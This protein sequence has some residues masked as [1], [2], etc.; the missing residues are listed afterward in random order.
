MVRSMSKIFAALVLVISSVVFF[1]GASTAQVEATQPLGSDADQIWDVADADPSVRHT[2]AIRALIWDIDEY[3]GKIYVAGKFLNVVAP[4]GAT[5]ER[6][7]L[8]AFDATT[9]AWV[10]SFQPQL[11]GAI[12]SLALTDS[13]RLL[14]GGEVTGGVVSIDPSTGAVDAGFAPGIKNS[15]GTPAVFDLET[16]GDVT[17]A[18]GRFAKA[19][20]T[21]LLNLAKFSTQTG[22]IDTAWTPTAEF[23]LGTPR[24]GG[25]LVYGIEVDESRD[26]VY[27]TGKFGSINGNT[28]AAYFATLDQATGTLKDVPQGL[29]VGTLNHRDSFSMWQHDVRYRGDKV[30]IG[31]QAH[32][33]LILNA[34]DLSPTASFFTNRGVG[35]SY[36]GGDTQTIFLGKNTLWAGCHCWGSV[37]PY[38]LGSYN[39]VHADGRQAYSEYAQW[40][41]DFATI[42][43][44]GQQ[45]VHGAYGIDLAT[46]KLSE[47]QFN[48]KGKGGAWA[49]FEASDG[50]LWMGGHFQPRIGSKD[51]GLARFSPQGSDELQPVAECNVETVDGQLHVSWPSAANAEDYVVYRSVNGSRQHWRGKTSNLQFVDSSRAGD[52]V[53]FV[54]S[55]RGNEKAARST[56]S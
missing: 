25:Q 54:A 6:P 30:Y 19:Q 29:P 49:L 55:K 42:D 56:C 11:D 15:W 5:Y 35:D 48:L 38:E 51:S 2:G 13:G 20:G 10:E 41:K 18:A 17:Y 45:K 52:I 1:P 14:A 31:G 27:V 26:R 28:D 21:Q 12:Y 4:D 24:I 23:D 3:E 8:A 50:R 32:Q 40:V 36:A 44:F 9:G 22:A 33:T 47:Q 7:Y 39:A 16:K 53:Y 37:G 34:D 43:P 46:G